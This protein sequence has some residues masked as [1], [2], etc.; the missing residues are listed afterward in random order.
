MSS[1][2]R[3]KRVCSH[4]NQP[5]VAQK[6]TTRFCSLI[7]AQRNYKL[8]KK[9]ERVAKA[10]EITTAQ[11][12][13][14]EFVQSTALKENG[15]LPNREIKRDWIVIRELAQSLAVGERSLFRAIKREGFPIL[16]IG[17]RMFFNREQ[18]IDFFINKSK[19]V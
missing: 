10:V 4:C 8:R 3:M 2:I 14:N 19:S 9:N 5:F 12:L 11:D 7:C 17:K 18:V 1:N 16:R 13:L 15:S 6:L